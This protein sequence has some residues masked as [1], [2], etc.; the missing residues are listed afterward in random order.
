AFAITSHPAPLTH[1]VG[2]DAFG[3]LREGAPN[4]GG[5]DAYYDAGSRGGA[6]SGADAA[7]GQVD[8]A[9]AVPVENGSADVLVAAAETP[10]H[11]LALAAAADYETILAAEESYWP[12][13]LAV[14]NLPSSSA[15]LD[16]D[17]RALIAIR[18]ATADPS[19]AIVASIA[20]QSAYAEDWTRDG[21]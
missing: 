14:A 19:G 12:S 6:L 8:A 21:S 16:V 20:R 15:N 1:Q 9:I 18:N 3:L 10:E 13:W 2:I 11:A 5:E 7:F 4:L 17:R